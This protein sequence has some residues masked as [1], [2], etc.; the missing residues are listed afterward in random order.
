MRKILI[1]IS[2]LLVGVFAI[3]MFLNAQNDPKEVKKVSTEVTKTCCK[4]STEASCCNK[5]MAS[6]T[7]ETKAC[8]KTKCQSA[9]TAGCDKKCCSMKNCDPSKCQAKCSDA[10]C[11]MKKCTSDCIATSKK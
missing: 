9:C 7:C 2:G 6:G 11:D 8:D 10:K 4:H 1:G 3:A 5:M